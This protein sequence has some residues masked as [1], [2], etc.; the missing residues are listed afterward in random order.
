[1]ERERL[2]HY[3][4]N[5]M[6]LLHKKLFKKFHGFEISKQQMHLLFA[7]NNNNGNPMKYYGE[8]LMIS[9]PNLSTV[10]NKLIQEELIERKNDVSDRRV[11]NLYITDKGKD[12][13]I[14]HRKAAKKNMLK[15]LGVLTDEDV[16]KLNHHFKEIESIFSKLK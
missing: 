4:F 3:I 14:T 15:K 7:I 9:K 12:F 6:P 11:I 13:L 5:F 10:V 1:M 8:K 2:I 16:K